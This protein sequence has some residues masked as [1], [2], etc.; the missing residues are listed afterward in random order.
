MAATKTEQHRAC[1]GSD[2]LPR[3]VWRYVF[4]KLWLRSDGTVMEEEGARDTSSVRLVCRT[5]AEDAAAVAVCIR[6]SGILTGAASSPLNKFH[7]VKALSFRRIKPRPRSVT[8]ADVAAVGRLSSLTS[9]DLGGCAQVTDV[10]LDALRSLTQLT[11]LN[12]SFC[13]RITAS[14]LASLAPL[15]GLK[16][17]N[18]EWC[19]IPD[20]GINALQ[21]LTSLET[22]NLS[23]CSISD[24]GVSALA[25][26]PSLR[27]LEVSCNNT[28]SV[29]AMESLR[30]A[31]GL[32]FV[33]R[34]SSWGMLTAGE[35][36]NKDS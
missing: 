27:R 9:L 30:K 24:A 14:G 33:H 2:C 13:H 11:Q 7:G 20:D 1:D 22:V 34:N 25:A 28:L 35:R 31:T 19:G 17:L 8:N 23:D 32:S 36:E 21:G 18:L 4:G 15:S 5:F 12:L 3:E 26:L 10:G 6:P 29:S 16:R